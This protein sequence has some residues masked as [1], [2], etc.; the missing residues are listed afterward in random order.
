VASRGSLGKGYDVLAVWRDW[1]DDVQGASL[2]RGHEL[3]ERSPS[4]TYAALR[5]FFAA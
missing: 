2:D 3:P 1:A 4:E 5:A